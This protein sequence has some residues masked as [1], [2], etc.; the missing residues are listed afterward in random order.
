MRL[1]NSN[2]PPQVAMQNA[3]RYIAMRCIKDVRNRTSARAHKTAMR[4]NRQ[5]AMRWIAM[6]CNRQIA[7]RGRRWA[8]MR[9]NGPSA[10]R[11][12]SKS[13]CAATGKSLY[14]AEDVPLCGYVGYRLHNNYAMYG[15]LRLEILKVPLKSH[16]NPGSSRRINVWPIGLSYYSRLEIN[17]YTML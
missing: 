14:G 6:R 7:I 16:R 2:T 11:W 9:C 3:M 5:N 10:M 4:C 15:D 12:L 17:R 8:A 13:L 1:A